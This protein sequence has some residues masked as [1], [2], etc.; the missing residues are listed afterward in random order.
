MAA[1]SKVRQS[2]FRHIFGTEFQAA[3]QFRDIRHSSFGVDGQPLK[4][5]A[6]H[7]AVPYPMPGAVCV[8]KQEVGKG[9]LDHESPPLFLHPSKEEALDCAFSPTSISP[10]PSPS[11]SSLSQNIHAFLSSSFSSLFNSFTDRFIIIG[12]ISRQWRVVVLVSA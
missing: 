2:K 7:F 9:A 3:E 11:F 10:I 1:S 12:D 6:T 4:A 5:T 8:V